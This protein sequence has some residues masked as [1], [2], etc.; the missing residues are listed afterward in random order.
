MLLTV[1]TLFKSV[2]SSELK[3]EVNNNTKM[4]YD[5]KKKNIKYY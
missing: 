3:K 2:D 4:R 1:V 5:E